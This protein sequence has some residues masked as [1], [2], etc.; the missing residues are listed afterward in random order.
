MNCPIC[1]T[2]L[3]S[4]THE[5]VPHLSCRQHGRW[6]EYDALRT[7]VVVPEIDRPDTEE[8]MALSQHGPVDMSVIADAQHERAC[9][10]CG[11][12]MTKLNYAY[13]S[14]VV[15][16]ACADHGIWL[17]TGEMHHL[18]AWY[19]G[20]KKLP[21]EE[22]ARWHERLGSVATDHADQTGRQLG[23]NS[24]FLGSVYTSVARWWHTR[25]DNTQAQR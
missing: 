15:V 22:A 23:Q 13:Q 19:E 24:R 11:Q 9:P 4:D 2:P 6:F 17:D 8:A 21:P 5:G 12:P 1:S 7:V 10:H 16:D 25:D 3:R 18:E 14:G 20:T